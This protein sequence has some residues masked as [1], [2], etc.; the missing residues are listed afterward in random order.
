MS[1]ED[2]IKV[3]VNVTLSVEV[4]VLYSVI[5]TVSCVIDTLLERIFVESFVLSEI[6]CTVEECVIEEEGDMRNCK[7]VDIFPDLNDVC[8]TVVLVSS[9]P[10]DKVLVRKSLLC[11]KTKYGVLLMCPDV[12]LAVVSSLWKLSVYEG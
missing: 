2:R 11:V 7:K 4:N 8:I 3:F 10:V 5:L 9:C 12:M 1:L 6:I